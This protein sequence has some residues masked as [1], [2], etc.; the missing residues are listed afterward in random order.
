MCNVSLEWD[1]FRKKRNFMIKV[2]QRLNGQR[3][4]WK[5]WFDKVLASVVHYRVSIIWNTK[6]AWIPSFYKIVP[7]IIYY[8]LLV[9][10]YVFVSIRSIMFVMKTPSMDEFV[11]NY[12]IWNSLNQLK[13]LPFFDSLLVN[14]ERTINAGNLQF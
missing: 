14:Y 13:F 1:K 6:G 3:S 12:T 10:F 8:I 9:N 7:H 5:I 11:Q 2:Y 4:L